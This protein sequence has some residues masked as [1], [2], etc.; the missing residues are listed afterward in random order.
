MQVYV[1]YDKET[2][3]YIQVLFDQ[4]KADKVVLKSNGRY[5]SEMYDL[6]EVKVKKKP[7]KSVGLFDGWF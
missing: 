4:K 6:P 3:E 2:K 7:K 1:I 5:I